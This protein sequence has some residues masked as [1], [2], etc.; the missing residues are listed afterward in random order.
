M[1]T[2]SCLLSS[3]RLV[4]VPTIK[5]L[6]TSKNSQ[7]CLL[8][9]YWRRWRPWMGW[10]STSLEASKRNHVTVVECKSKSAVTYTLKNSTSTAHTHISGGAVGAFCTDRFSSLDL[11][12]EYWTAKWGVVMARIYYQKLAIFCWVFS[13]LWD[14][15]EWSGVIISPALNRP[16]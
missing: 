1:G 8:T 2:K 3:P 12:K 7:T 6:Y 16:S 15:W 9:K 14:S 5:Y 10:D 11:G 13:H 4:Y